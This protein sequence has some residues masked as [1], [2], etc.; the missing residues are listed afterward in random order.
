MGTKYIESTPGGREMYSLGSDPEEKRDVRA[1][2]VELAAVLQ[3]ALSDWA[4]HQPK[5]SGIGATPDQ[6]LKQLKSLGY[7]Q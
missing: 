4:A 3:G 7:V 2:N 1:D 5:L 6:V